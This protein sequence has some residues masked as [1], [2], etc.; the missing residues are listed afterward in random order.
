M[1]WSRDLTRLS[2]NRPSKSMF[3]YDSMDDARFNLC[4]SLM[5]GGTKLGMDVRSCAP[6]ALR[7]TDVSTSVSYWPRK[8]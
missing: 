7:P 8:P 2:I 3:Y 6:R 4:N 1:A 5:V